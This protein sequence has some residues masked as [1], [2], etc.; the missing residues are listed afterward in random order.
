MDYELE[1]YYEDEIGNQLEDTCGD[2][3]DQSHQ[4]PMQNY[5]MDGISDDGDLTDEFSEYMHY[6]DVSLDSIFTQ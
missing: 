2:D 3:T 5:I 1:P 4:P 6:H